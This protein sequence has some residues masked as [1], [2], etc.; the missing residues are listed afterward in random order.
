MHLFHAW[1]HPLTKCYS[2]LFAKEVASP[3][4]APGVPMT[5]RQSHLCPSG[6]RPP[7]AAGTGEQTTPLTKQT[8]VCRTM[9]SA[10]QGAQDPGGPAATN[11]RVGTTASRLTADPLGARDTCAASLPVCHRLAALWDQ[12]PCSGA[13]CPVTCQPG[14]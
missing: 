7:R 8:L 13:P 11:Q 4:L 6:G 9:A 14:D 3:F 10:Q 1:F 5:V 12:R 2:L